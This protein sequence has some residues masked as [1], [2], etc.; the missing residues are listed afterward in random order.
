MAYIQ[1]FKISKFCNNL[2]TSKFVTP[3]KLMCMFCIQNLFSIMSRFVSTDTLWIQCD[4][5][6]LSLLL[7]PLF[8]Y[9]HL[10]LTPPFII[11]PFS[12][13]TPPCF[14]LFH[15]C[16]LPLA[17]YSLLCLHAI[18]VFLSFM[19]ILSPFLSFSP[20]LTLMS[21]GLYTDSVF[22]QKG[23]MDFHYYF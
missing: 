20:F 4:A 12:L 23:F 3:P 13:L 16:L 17:V 5:L 9:R 21:N 15:L 19:F 7:L 18:L 10:L 22:V 14:L 2:Y 6:F 1:N 11:L 8:L